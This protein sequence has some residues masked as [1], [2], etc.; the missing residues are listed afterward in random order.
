M[1][2]IL[3]EI[4]SDLLDKVKSEINGELI[5]DRL[6]YN[7]KIDK[8]ELIDYIDAETVKDIISKIIINR[9]LQDKVNVLNS[10]ASFLTDPYKLHNAKEGA[11]LIAEFLYDEDA[12]IYIYADYDADGLMSGYV[13]YSALN[14]ISK[15]NI[16]LKYPNRCEGYGLSMDFCKHLVERHSSDNKVLVMTVDNGI[17]KVEE[18]KFLKENNIEVLITDHH[19]SKDEVPDCLIVNPHNNTIKQ[20]DTFKHLCGCGVA[21]KVAQIV[22]EEHGINNMYNYLPYFAIATITDVMPLN[23]ENLSV[24]QYG[25]DIMNSSKCPKGIS[26]LKR[27]E[28]IDLITTATIGWVIGPMLNAC[29]RMGDTELG[30]KM[31]FVDNETIVDDIQEIISI[32]DRR[33]RLTKSAVEKLSKITNDD[34][35]VLIYESKA[36]AGILGI[37]AGKAVEIFNKPAMV[38]TNTNG[39]LHGSIR[40]INNLDLLPA[41]R[42]LEEEEIILN[43]GGHAGALAIYFEESK[44]EML[45]NRL[46]EL[47]YIEEVATESEELEDDLLIDYML[48]LDDLNLIVLALTSIFPMDGKSITE[49]TFAI[50]DL[51]LKSFKTYPSGYMEVKVKQGKTTMTMSAMGYARTFEEKVLPLLENEDKKIIH[52]AGKIKKHFKTKRYVLDIVDIIGG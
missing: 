34:N 26:M 33:K 20:E 4:E 36:P 13:M 5:L 15:C 22:Q 28:E 3:R 27:I 32:N 30:A 41:M 45:Q 44:K 50:T 10:P 19:S 2:W 9:D 49:P 31:L 42:I 25:L 24:I 12:T 18:V 46:N 1:N 17:T 38:V 40:S 6:A 52:I 16:V 37:I 29:G 39:V 11:D 21:F 47:I 23:E 35:K 7:L 48:T 14:E 43:F 51:E 8:N